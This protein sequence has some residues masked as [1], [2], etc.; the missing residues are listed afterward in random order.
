MRR[1]RKALLAIDVLLAEVHV[2]V[3]ARVDDLDVEPLAVAGADVRGDDHERA[4]VRRVPHALGRRV[5]RRGQRELDRR[6]GQREAGEQRR[7]GE[8]QREGAEARGP[9]GHTWQE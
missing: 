1:D 4:R 6:R 8:E 2:L 5:A 9:A 3:L 7:G